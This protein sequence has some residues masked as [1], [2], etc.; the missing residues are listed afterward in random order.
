MQV[1]GKLFPYP[2]LN[3]NPVFS[4]YIGC[5]FRLTFEDESTDDTLILRNIGYETNS[6]TL[7]KLIEEDKVGVAIIFEAPHSIIREKFDVSHNKIDIIKS[8]HQLN[9]KIE[10]SIFAYAKDNFNYSPDE[11]DDDYNGLTFNIEKYDIVL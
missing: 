2:V 10:I 7:Q 8:K 11:A 9:K 6:L 3:S 1:K 5:S 4:N